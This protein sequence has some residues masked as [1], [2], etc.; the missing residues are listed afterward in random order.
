MLTNKI[1][2]LLVVFIWAICC[3]SA[4]AA[5]PAA[6]APPALLEQVQRLSE[7][8]RDG[9][10]VLYP[11]ATMVQQVTVSKGQQ[12]ALVAFSVEGYGG[13]NNH[14]QYFAVF[15]MEPDQSGV[16]FYSLLDVMRIGGKGWRSVVKLNAKVIGQ[17][18]NGA[19]LISLDGLEVTTGDAPNFPSKKITISLLFKDGRLIEQ[20]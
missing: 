7:L 19:T 12:W 20:N 3:A 2:R 1:Q 5:A 10:A 6:K 11:D 9:Y 8:L 13:G 17:A 4:A 14:R 15:S 16:T 18:K